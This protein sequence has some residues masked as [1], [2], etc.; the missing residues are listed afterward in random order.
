MRTIN[1]PIK[2]NGLQFA[3]AVSCIEQILVAGLRH[4]HFRCSIVGEV[5]NNKRRE[6]VIEAGMSYKFTI[7]FDDLPG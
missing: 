6:L 1:T 2:S 5:S 3:E 7:P 4:G